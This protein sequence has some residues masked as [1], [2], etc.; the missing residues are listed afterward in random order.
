VLL[1]AGEINTGAFDDFA[2]LIPIAHRHGAWV[3]VDGAFGLWASASP[4]YRHLTA[5]VAEAD[6]WATDGHKWLNVP[7]DCGYA[8]VAHPREHRAAM[9]Y[10]ASYLPAS[11]ACRDELDWTPE[12][13]RRARGFATYAA[14]RQLGRGGVARLVEGCCEAARGMIEGLRGVPGVEI[15]AEPVINQALVRFPDPAGQDHD[16]HT[17]EVIRRIQAGGEAFFGGTSW[18]GMRCMRISVSNWQTGPEDV[19]RSVAAIAQAVAE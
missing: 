12:F 7:Y 6:S 10:S 5:G 4:R 15:L 17:D 3:H 9:T 1:Q 18:R 2:A 14:L 8:F 16:R 19:R 13:S 11:D